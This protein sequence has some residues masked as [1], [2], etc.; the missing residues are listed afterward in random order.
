MNLD[1][2]MK[3]LPWIILFFIILIGG[4]SYLSGL[5]N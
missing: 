5:F 1:A 2:I 3:Y 4:V